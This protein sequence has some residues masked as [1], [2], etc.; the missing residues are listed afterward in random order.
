MGLRECGGCLSRWAV[1]MLLVAG[2]GCGPGGGGKATGGN[3]GMEAGTGGVTGTGGSGNTGGPISLMDFETGALAAACR[4]LV[5]CGAAADQTTC[6]AA[7]QSSPPYVL[8]TLQQDVSS[9]KVKYDGIQAAACLA[10]YGT[11]V[12]TQTWNAGFQASGAPLCAKVFTGT[13]ASGGT[14]FLNAECAPGAI[15]SFQGSS[16]D[17]ST[18]CCPGTCMPGGATVALNGDCSDTTS[19]CVFGTYCDRSGATPLCLAQATTEGATCSTGQ[20]A[21]P[22]FCDPVTGTCMKPAPSGATCAFN[23]ATDS[24]SC[25]DAREVCD[26]TTGTC[27]AP[28]AVNAPCTS[29]TL[30][31]RSTYCDAAGTGTCV[32]YLS[33]GASCASSGARCLL[34]LLC[35]PITSTCVLPAATACQ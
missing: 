19:T 27:V 14:C 3:G 15:C 11:I 32:A 31:P 29:T 34:D 6:L 20:C 18:Q 35:D 8:P 21:L 17:P 28:V 22:L 12:C 13:I 33:A 10:A 7:V 1:V 26:P 2:A 25:D 24:V 16:C 9:G 5:A 30:C 4:L 23:S